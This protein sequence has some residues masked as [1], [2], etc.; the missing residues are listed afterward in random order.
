MARRALD[1]APRARRGGVAV[2]AVALV[3]LACLAVGVVA[4]FAVRGGLRNPFTVEQVD[5]SEPAVLLALQD[6]SEYRAASG[7]YHV[8]VDV[9]Q[10][11]GMLPSFL[12]GERTLYVGLGTVDAAVDLGELGPDR[13]QVVPGPDGTPGSVRITLPPAELTPPRLDPDGSYVYSQSR[14]L[15]DRIEDALSSAP[16]GEQELQRQAVAMLEDAA[17]DSD[18]RDRA[19]ANTRAMLEALL[20]SL[21]FDRVDVTFDAAPPRP[22]APDLS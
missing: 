19:E 21:G 5:R 20:E 7:Q 8:I 13:V 3:A 10:D 14:G 17:E 18:L 2:I 22:S 4:G 9:E 6:L 12:A 15:V 11:V 16:E 1:L